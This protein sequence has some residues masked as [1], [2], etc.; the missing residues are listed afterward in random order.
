MKTQNKQESEQQD[1]FGSGTPF[2]SQGR[3]GGGMPG[4]CNGCFRQTTMPPWPPTCRGRK[5]HQI[6]LW[7]LFFYIDKSRSSTYYNWESIRKDCRTYE[8][9]TY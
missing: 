9:G 4:P 2:P 6:P 3:S 5:R 8:N 1:V 7:G